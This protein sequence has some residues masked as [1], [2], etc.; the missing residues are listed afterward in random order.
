MVIGMATGRSPL[1]TLLNSEISV[2]ISSIPAIVN[3]RYG[4]G[5]QQRYVLKA[6][7]QR[8]AGEGT[9]D[10]ELPSYGS[11]ASSGG[12]A[13]SSWL[14]RGYILEYTKVPND[15]ELG[16]RLGGY[17]FESI[18]TD[19]DA[20]KVAIPLYP[21]MQCKLRHG[22]MRTIHNAEIV[23]IGGRYQGLGPDRTIYMELRGVQ[24]LIKGSLT[25]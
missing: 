4:E 20:P 2:N 10:G 24:V 9:D 11:R 23:M 19:G 14:F 8:G 5:M 12:G 15:F 1:T 7:L 21:S 18:L 16:S 25:I 6:Y 22:D 17:K 3:G 13:T